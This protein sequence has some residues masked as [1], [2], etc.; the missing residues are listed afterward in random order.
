M[1][2]HEVVCVRDTFIFGWQGHV[3]AI[4]LAQIGI[5]VAWYC[6]RSVFE[7]QFHHICEPFGLEDA[8]FPLC[9]AYAFATST[10]CVCQFE[11]EKCLKV[12][13]RIAFAVEVEDV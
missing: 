8:S 11:V 4:E 9:D 12:A 7:W 6:D 5:V 13:L 1:Q 10:S 2:V 3:V